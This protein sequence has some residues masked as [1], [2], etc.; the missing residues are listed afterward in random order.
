[1][2]QAYTVEEAREKFLECCQS[3]VNYWENESRATT[4]R[5][6]LE[7]LMFSILSMLDGCNG[8]MPAFLVIP[9]PHESDEEYHKKRGE[10]YYVREDIGG[11]LHEEYSRMDK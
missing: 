4:S 2:T 5:E 7:G 1:M 6:K 11:C 10:K 3:L 8:E 9:H